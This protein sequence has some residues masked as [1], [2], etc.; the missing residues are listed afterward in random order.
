MCVAHGLTIPARPGSDSLPTLPPLRDW[1]PTL[2]RAHSELMRWSVR[3]HNV[4]QQHHQD[5]GAVIDALFNDMI[6]ILHRHAP[7][8]RRCR[9]QR[10][11]S[12]WTPQCFE[13]HVARNGALR[14]YRRTLTPELHDRFRIA[15]TNFHRVARRAQSEFWSQWQ[16][17]VANLSRVNPCAAATRI[18]QT[19]HGHSRRDQSLAVRWPQLTSLEPSHRDVLDQWRQHFI[20][21]GAQ[22]GD[23]FRSTM[24]RFTALSEEPVSRGAFDVPFSA[25]DL[26]QALSRCPESAVGAD[27]LPYCLFKVGSLGGRRHC[28]D[29]RPCGSTAS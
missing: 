6:S 19:F 29:S 20:T 4:G 11:P 26:R 23:S 14:D 1:K 7:F 24:R 27:G 13:A 2:M 22:V 21:V 25:A 8:Q 12:W 9:R 3:I 10:Q 28:C 17:E 18:R 15:R 5:R 16:D